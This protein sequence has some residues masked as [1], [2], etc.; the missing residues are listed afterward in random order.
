M[1]VNELIVEFEKLRETH[2]EIDTYPVRVWDT[3]GYISLLKEEI[4]INAVYRCVYLG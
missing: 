4:A 3:K 1:T 2:P